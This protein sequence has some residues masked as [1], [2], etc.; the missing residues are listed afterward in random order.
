M[1]FQADTL[2]VNVV[3]PTVSETTALGAAYMAGLAMGLWDNLDDL[4]RG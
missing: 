4:T 1:Q 2:G 3:W